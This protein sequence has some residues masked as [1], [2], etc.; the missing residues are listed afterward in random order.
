MTGD[1]TC[2]VCGTHIALIKNRQ[3]IQGQTYCSRSLCRLALKDIFE[4][5]SI[6]SADAPTRGLLMM[7]LEE[8]VSEYDKMAEKVAALE[9]LSLET[10][11]IASLIGTTPASVRATRS[12]EG[13]DAE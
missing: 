12:N 11:T 8:R 3:K 13:N 7:E 6:E 4:P 2:E 5:D 10:K 1:D 9:V